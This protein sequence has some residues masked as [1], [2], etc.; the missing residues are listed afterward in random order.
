MTM[1]IFLPK[2]LK[3]ACEKHYRLFH[4]HIVHN[5]SPVQLYRISLNKKELVFLLKSLLACQTALKTFHKKASV[6]RLDWKY[7][8][9]KNTTR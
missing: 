6:K 4:S 9:T 7:T 8:V 5:I 3:S 1:D 2:L